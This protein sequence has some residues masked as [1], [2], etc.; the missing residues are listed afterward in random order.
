RHEQRLA[1]VGTLAGGVAHEFNNILLPLILYTEEALD[2]IRPEHPAHP[3]LTRVMKAAI[4]ASDVV[5]KL[6]SF[7]RPRADRPFGPVRLGRVVN[8]ALDLSQAL[9]PPNVQLR[10]EITSQDERILA[11]AT[12]LNQ[13]VLNL[14]SNAVLAIGAREGVD[15]VSVTSCDR[16]NATDDHFR[17]LQLRLKDTGIGMSAEIQERIFEPFFTTRDVGQGSGLGLSIVHGIVTS[18]G[19]HIEVTSVPGQGTEF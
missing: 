18:L 14:C 15:T 13:V 9:I 6:L 16:V 4:R 17:V 19:G 11:D 3:N 5:S 7:S 12:L 8:E 2:D 1:T 10:R